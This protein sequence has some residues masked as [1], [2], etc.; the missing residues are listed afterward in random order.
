M[1]S[2]QIFLKSRANWS[3]SKLS[4]LCAWQQRRTLVMIIH[5]HFVYSIFSFG[6]DRDLDAKVGGKC[7]LGKMG[8]AMLFRSSSIRVWCDNVSGDY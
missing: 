1:K 4:S 2:S 5:P 3:R 8:N 6:E 7:L